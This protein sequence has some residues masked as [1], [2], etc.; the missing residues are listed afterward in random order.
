MLRPIFF[1]LYLL[2]MT[3][4]TVANTNL[5]ILRTVFSVCVPRWKFF[6]KHDSQLVHKTKTR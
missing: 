6:S 3:N 4:N 1:L 5:Q 2:H